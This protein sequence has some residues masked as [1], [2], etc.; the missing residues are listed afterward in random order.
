MG[1]VE[2]PGSIESGDVPRYS[3]IRRYS[4][5]NMAGQNIYDNDTFFENFEAGMPA[6][7][8]TIDSDGDGYS[9]MLGSSQMGTGYGHY[10]SADCVY[11]ESYDN[12]I[13]VLYPD[14]YLV[15]PQVTLGTTSIFSFYA[16]AQD[17]N[18]A[19]EHFGVAISTTG[20]TPSNFTVVQ[21][22]TMTAKSGGNLM[23]IGRDGA[24]RAQGNWYQY[25]VDLSAYAGQKVYIAIRHFNCSDMFYLDVDDIELSNAKK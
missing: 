10:G 6:G 25:T 24:N 7:W 16:C 20:T 14:N 11:S 15:S 8:T 17:A 9:W 22:W 3:Y 2:R 18:Y 23:S 21:E 19:A 1:L 13:G 5:N 12:S 4:S